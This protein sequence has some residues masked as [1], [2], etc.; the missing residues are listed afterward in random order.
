MYVMEMD[1]LKWQNAKNLQ[2]F[3]I[4]A[5]WFTKPVLSIDVIKIT[6]MVMKNL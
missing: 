4:K 5:S 6:M 2:F 1:S 3:K